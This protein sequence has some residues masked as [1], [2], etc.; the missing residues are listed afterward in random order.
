MVKPLQPQQAQAIISAAEALT[1]EAV[2]FLQGLIR[3]PTVNPPGHAYPECA[4]YI[5]EHLRTT[6]YEVEYLELTPAEVE[7]LAPYGGNMP[8]TNVIG[9]L[10]DPRPGPVLHFNGHMDVVPVGPGWSTDPFSGELRDGRVFGR[11]ASDMKGGIAAQIF[12]VEAIRRAGLTLQGTIEQSGVVDEESTGNRNAGMGF[13][14]E[15]GYIA[16]GKTDYVVITEPL[17]VDNVCLGHRGAIWGEITTFGLPSHGST[18][19]RGV[20][21]VEHMA[22]FIDAATRTLKPRLQQRLNSHP[23]VPASASAASISFNIIQG[24]T[25][26]N[27]VPD[28]CSAVFD[29]R[30]VVGEDLETAR[31]EITSILEQC[32]RDIPGFRYNYSE[33]YATVPTWVSAETPLVAAFTEAVEEVL[34]RTPGYVC[35]PGTDDQRF[36]VHN[37][38]IEQC[39][40]YGPGEIIQTHNIDESLAVADLVA[41]IKVMALAAASLLGVE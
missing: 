10:A 28:S 2:T 19:E 26:T 41:S 17:N 29:R 13:L 34:G 4:H 12:A 33:R 9:R 1:D 20:N 6:G 32:A 18:P 14:V 36:V 38:G 7:E 39:I 24:G 27:S 8:R 3:I 25:N 30:L 16:A 35:S 5:G 40:V 37:A 21:A 23:V 11:G 31:Q 15:R 22:H